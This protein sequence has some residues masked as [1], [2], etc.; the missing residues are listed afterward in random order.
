MP[1]HTIRLLLAEDIEIL[2]KGLK[3]LLAGHPQLEVAGEAGD[4]V[5]A[6][7]M[8]MELNPDVILMDLSMPRMDGAD[9]IAEIKRRSPQTGILALTAYM[10]PELVKKTLA[11]GADGYLL[12]NVKADELAMAIEKVA[13][14]CP[15]VCPEIA[16]MLIDS[17]VSP[18]GHAVLEDDGLLTGREREVLAFIASG[19]TCKEV[20]ARLDLSP[21][22]V[23]THKVNIKRKIGVKSSA[24]M[25]VYAIERGLAGSSSSARAS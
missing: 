10:E 22:T 13:G 7:R 16:Q 14:G 11:A 2:R 4:G 8:A 21:K 17:F 19:L 15:Y 6:V 25:I 9:A 24:E 20:A 5:E 23:D 1:D 18:G 3:V 12:K